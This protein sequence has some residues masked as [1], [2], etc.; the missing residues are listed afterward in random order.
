MT[1]FRTSVVKV[2]HALAYISQQGCKA[3]S[4]T[5]PATMNLLFEAECRHLATYGRPITGDHYIAEP[6]GVRGRAASGLIN[7]EP[8]AM[9]WL[10]SSGRFASPNRPADDAANRAFEEPQPIGRVGRGGRLIV[11]PPLQDYDSEE[12]GIHDASLP[13]RPDRVARTYW[14]LSQSDRDT[15][16]CICG[17]FGGFDADAWHD[18]FARWPFWL[19]HQGELIPLE[20]ILPGDADKSADILERASRTVL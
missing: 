7:H 1:Q 20:A 18:R 6:F 11:Y 13:R 3:T 2:E 4:L 5:A 14:A 16:D 8:V 17:L 19:A 15:L 12:V 10:Q 9:S